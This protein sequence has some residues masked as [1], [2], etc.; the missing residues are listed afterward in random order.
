[1]D[2]ERQ[3]IA[4]RVLLR[5]TQPGEG[6][7]DTRRR[8]E[9][10][11]LVTR[12]GR[13]GA[14][15]TTWS[16]TLAE[17]RLRDDRHATRPGAKPVVEVTH[18][19]LIRGWPELRGWID[20]D[21]DRLR[22]ERRLSDAAAQWDRGGRDEGGLYRGARLAAWGERDDEST[23]HALGAGAS[24]RELGR[25]R[26]ASG[27]AGAAG[28]D[29]RWRQS[30]G[31]AAWSPA[32]AIFA[33]SSG[34]TRTTSATSPRHGSW[35]GARRWP[36]ARPGA[37]DAARRERLRG[38]AHRRGRGEPAPGR[39]RVRDPR[40]AP[41]A[42]QAAS[43]PPRHRRVGSRSDSSSGSLQL[44]DPEGDP[45]GA[46]PQAV[47]TWP[48]GISAPPASDDGGIRDR[49]QDGRAGAVAG[50][51]APGAPERI[52]S[53]PARVEYLHPLSGGD[54]VIAATTK[55]AWVV[56]L[57]D[58]R[59]RRVVA[60]SFYDAVEGA[61]RPA[62]T[63]PSGTDF[64][65]QRWTT[66][67]RRPR[68]IPVHERARTIAVSP[69]GALLAIA[70]GN[71]VDV[72]RLADDSL[73]FSAPVKA[74]STRSP[75]PRTA[76]G[77]RRRAATAQCRS[78]RRTD[79]CCPGTSG[80]KASSPRSGSSDP[81]P[82]RAWGPTGRCACGTR[83]R[84]S[85]SSCGVTRRR[86]SGGVTFDDRAPDHPGRGGRRRRKLESGPRG[87]RA[88][89]AR[90][91]GCARAATRP[92]RPPRTWSPS[93]SQDG[94]VIVRDDSRRPG[95]ER[96]LP[97]RAAGGVALD[98][99]WTAG[100]RRALRQDASRSSTSPLAPSRRSSGVTGAR[101][102]PT[103]QYVHVALPGHAFV[104]VLLGGMRGRRSRPRRAKPGARGP[105]MS[106]GPHAQ[107]ANP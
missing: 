37:G 100:G 49:R 26:S 34:T 44:W 76:T 59:P 5:L 20:E 106:S 80:T 11:E 7:E 21:R 74:A 94:R 23:S 38:L 1:M 105:S 18:E 107:S 101:R 4:R 98:P 56:D 89:P 102:T 9:R 16:K 39:P 25:A 90:G 43:P 12:P 27:H 78:T 46:S 47:G 63:S 86:P 95:R 32:I 81:T 68:P 72:H 3:A 40:D 28:P 22:A 33:S 82:S 51:A 10:R 91:P 15:S 103:Q 77:S 48:K 17:A 24:S 97:G 6:A 79:G 92:P 30:P 36:A 53:L 99:A 52:A 71:G 70:T 66:A 42:G 93:A 14:R 67:R 2:P 75:G 55:G 84:A 57:A 61:G 96:L 54:G 41:D 73:V 35:P 58:R 87:R 31:V 64:T 104:T 85:S 13:A 62:P 83:W 29:R 8:A 69:D 45:R 60:G 65:V 19:A 88:A 50:P